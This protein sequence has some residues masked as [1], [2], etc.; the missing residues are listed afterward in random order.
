MASLIISMTITSLAE[1]RDRGVTIAAGCDDG[2]KSRRVLNYLCRKDGWEPWQSS[3]ATQLE[4]L[5]WESLRRPQWMLSTVGPWLCDH[6]TDGGTE[7]CWCRVKDAC[8]R[9]D[10]WYGRALGGG[11]T[12]GDP[13]YSGISKL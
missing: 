2:W 12:E 4:L 9:S 5:S 10:K 8:C 11:E 6:R 1:G 3:F 13:T 7:C